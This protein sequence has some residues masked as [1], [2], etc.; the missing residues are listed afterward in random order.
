MFLMHDETMHCN[1]VSFS[2]EGKN[3]PFYNTALK[4]TTYQFFKA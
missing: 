2:E 1:N 3:L 4:T